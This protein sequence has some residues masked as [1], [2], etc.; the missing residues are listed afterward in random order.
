MLL[1]G[2]S[3]ELM[4]R[5]ILFRGMLARFR[6]WPAVLLSSSLFGL[7]HTL[8][9][10][11]TG[12]LQPALMQ[13]MAAFMQG[14]AYQAIRIRTGSVWPMVVVHG[15][16]DFSLVLPGLSHPEG[17]LAVQPGLLPLLIALP[18]FLYGLFLMRHLDRDD[19]HWSDAAPVPHAHGGA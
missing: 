9:V 6:I 16:W 3:E 4:F 7:V 1:V 17:E 5:S 2:L 15:S 8:N 14:L 11:A 18:V 12:Q 13:A 10:F 19:G